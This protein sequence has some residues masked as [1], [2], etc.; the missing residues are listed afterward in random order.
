MAEDSL[1]WGEP[2]E[3][4]SMPQ[5]AAKPPRPS[6]RP[7]R[8]GLVAGPSS[9]TN[10]GPVVRHLV[11]GLLD[12]PMHV[13]LVCREDAD[14]SSVPAPPV[15]L[16][17]YGSVRLPVVGRR[18][19][20]E[21]AGALA[22]SG[23]SVLHALDAD[24]LPLTRRLAVAADLPYFLSVLSLA[25][26]VQGSDASCRSV[27][28]AS[29]PIEQ[30]LSDS[31]AA[32][33][34]R[35]RLLPPGVHRVRKATCFINAQHAPALVAAG[36]LDR[37]EH[38]AAVLEAFARL[39]ARRRD[40]AFF[41]VGAGRCEGQ[42]R[43]LAER[44]ALMDVTTF[45]QPQD[46]EQLSGIVRAADIFISPAPS[47]RVEIELLAAMAAGDPVVAAGAE[48]CDF[49]INGQ[50]ALTY[51]PADADDL[52]GRLTAL[53]DDRAWARRLAENALAH[54]RE[55]HSPARMAAT[56][57]GLY[58]EATGRRTSPE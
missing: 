58:R 1:A 42:L 52:A 12:E 7:L 25:D 37:M 21:L 17:R 27:L 50:T 24:A 46:P 16:V 48:A 15:S 2:I 26:D 35:I 32:P 9:L 45:V 56:L 28:A 41:V 31:R 38:F 57:A 40:C 47:E 4:A 36:R 30:R 8:V 33:S 14:V 6:G 11:V 10:L 39:R 5:P 51:A 29:R 18:A 34:G 13:S 44:L 3:W 54:L 23:V 55:H 43:V 22:A 20:S 19:V 53:L 49:I